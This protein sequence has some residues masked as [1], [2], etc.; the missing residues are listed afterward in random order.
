LI[1]V[2]QKDHCSFIFEAQ[3]CFESWAFAGR[4]IVA[5]TPTRKN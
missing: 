2:L 5:A 1:P 3:F 4:L